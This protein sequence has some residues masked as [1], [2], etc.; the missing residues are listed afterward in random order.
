MTKRKDTA[1]NKGGRPKTPPED[2]AR[3]MQAVCER[4]AKGELV[5]YAAKEEGTSA[6]RIRE[7]A[8]LPEYS[9]LYA[10]ARESQAHA[11]AEE[12]LEIADGEDGL[13]ALYEEAAEH[14][15]DE[16]KTEAAKQAARS[17]ATNI[18]TRD[19]MR[20]DARKWL[21]SK[22][23]PKLFGDKVDLTSDGEKLSGV[24]IL[25]PTAE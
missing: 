25:P 24:V 11:L 15:M 10:R 23:A 1:P 5:K 17:L 3:L 21:T 4:V 19:R 14:A 13:T 12:A 16:A 22:I 9:A 18:I 8:L 20:L 2:V 7:W 6:Q